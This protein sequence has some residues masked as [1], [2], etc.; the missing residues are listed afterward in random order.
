MI[1]SFDDYCIHQTVQPVAD[2]AQGDRNFYDRYWFNGIEPDGHWIFEIG[3]GL[4]P[5][6]QVMDAHFSVAIRNKQYAFHASRRAPTERSETVVGPLSVQIIKPMRQ[7]RIIL[8]PN[9]HRIECDL[10][11][12]A[13]S[14]AYQEPIDKRSYE[15]ELIVHSSRFIQ[16]GQWKGY[17]AI[18]GQ[19]VDVHKAYATR[20]KS[21]GVRPV[22]EAM[23]TAADAMG[24]YRI[25]NPIHFGDVCTLANMLETN[26]GNTVQSDVALLPLYG[27]IQDIPSAG[28]VGLTAMQ[29]IEHHISWHKGTRRASAL[30]I[31]FADEQGNKYQISM[32]T[33]QRFYMLGVG[34]NHPE[35][36]HAQW[37]GELETAREQ[38]DFSMI[39][40]LEYSFVHNHQVVVAR[41]RDSLG[42]ERRG[43]GTLATFVVGR[44]QPSGFQQYLDG[45]P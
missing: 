20:D 19:R 4:Y 28:D 38:W 17:F 22:G 29:D 23:L 43:I 41:L 35:W 16:M 2:S 7:I 1:T 9:E 30:D 5:N 24:V 34:F 40:E 6:R 33:S 32:E 13:T 39:D 37:Q 26:G 36:G 10:L 3:F 8:L 42:I 15:G 44:H 45:A 18:D 25:W 14:T 11:F 27:K 31:N 12:S 21:W